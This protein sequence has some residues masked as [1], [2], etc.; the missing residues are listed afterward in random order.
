MPAPVKI[1][2]MTVKKGPTH[3]LFEL[4]ANGIPLAVSCTL[5]EFYEDKEKTLKC[6][7]ENFRNSIRIIKLYGD[8]KKFDKKMLNVWT[9]TDTGISCRGNKLPVNEFP[10]FD[11]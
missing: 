7:N 3:M 5:Q 6:V 10:P 1:E 9:S 11:L 4:R 8:V 2:N